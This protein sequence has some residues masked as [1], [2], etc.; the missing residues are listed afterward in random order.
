MKCLMG[1]QEAQRLLNVL[2]CSS[3]SSP[4]ALFLLGLTL[5]VLGAA[6]EALLE[7]ALAASLLSVY[8]SKA[9]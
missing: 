5:E 7:L 3:S 4:L 2:T 8:S 1:C 9:A 6:L